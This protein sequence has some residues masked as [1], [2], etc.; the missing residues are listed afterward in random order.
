MKHKTDIFNALIRVHHITSRRKV[1]AIS[2]SAKKHNVYA[3]L[4]IGS[5]PGIMY[6]EGTEESVTDWVGDV[7]VS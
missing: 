3:V 7:K 5:P 1:A 2:Q 4:H 6:A